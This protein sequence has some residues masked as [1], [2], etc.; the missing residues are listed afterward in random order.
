MTQF[1]FHILDSLNDFIWGYIGFILIFLLGIFL[2]IKSKLF[3]IRKFPRIFQNFSSFLM[4]K[5]EKD[6]D[7]DEIGVHPL[8]AFFAA[9]GGCIGIGNI[10]GICTAV[11]IGGP[12]A[13]FWTWIAGFLGM[14]IQ[15]SEVY[16][17]MKYR[18]KND[19]GG[20]DGG[21]MYFL[22]KAFKG[23][24]I[25]ILI[26]V[27]LAIYGVEVFMFNVITDS[28]VTNWHFNKEVVVGLLLVASIFAAS[29][30]VKRVGKIAS[31]VIPL[32]IILYV[33]MSF[34]ILA[35]NLYLIPDVF[36]MIL[37]GAF[38]PQAAAGTFAGSTIILT[39]SMG[40]SRGAY[41]GDI[42]VGYTSVIHSETRS[43]HPE[44]QASL[45]II[46]IF[47]DT[48]VV[49]T[50]S[51]LLAL[52]TGVWKQD[53]DV[54]VMI[55]TA[56]GQ[57]FPYMNF[58]MPFFLFLLGYSTIISYFVVGL[59]C[60]RF[61]SPKK[62]KYLYYLYAIIVMPLFAYVNSEQALTVMSLA[63]AF[64]LIFNLSGIFML[65]KQ[66]QFHA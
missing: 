3:Q 55:Q 4:K 46:G 19:H 20:Y 9:I 54:T 58:F 59:K 33:L 26:S 28:V 56:L 49:C 38:T 6:E 27:L 47:L 25:A 2:C 63:G 64:L 57:Y 53:I 7:W 39:I 18:V 51:I 65:R 34:W 66:V 13:L 36:R 23:K 42:G 12:G 8:K 32:F 10:V 35:K 15:Y 16:L 60:S 44:K 24:W 31:A 5:E 61:I 62:G 22:P 14:L 45:T 50:L 30:G 43:K 48:F 17:G 52:V 29:G 40:L 41:S 1:I 37:E 11:K 21:P